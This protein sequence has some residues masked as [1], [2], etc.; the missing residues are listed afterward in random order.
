[1]LYLVKSLYLL[2]LVLYMFME[3]ILFY[4]EYFV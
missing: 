2:I 4:I 1:M 3:F